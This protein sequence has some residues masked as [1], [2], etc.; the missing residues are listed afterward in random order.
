[1][2]SEVSHAVAGVSYKGVRY[3]RFSYND[4]GP[5]HYKSNRGLYNG[6]RNLEKRK[7]IK[8]L[9]EDLFVFTSKGKEWFESSISRYF[10]KR[11]PEWDG[12]WRVVIFDIP[13]ELHTKRNQFRR[14]LKLMG[15][16]MLQKS[17][18]VFPYPC[19]E[20]IG[21]ICNKLGLADCVDIIKAESAG[22]RNDELMK[23]FRL[24]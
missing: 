23:F 17:V 18:F 16:H 24:R 6:F 19:E 12:K 15:F 13:K 21:D 2:A 7:I 10:K 8:K 20:E 5:C 14:R 3:R 22:F 1:M 4:F 9:D 11:Y